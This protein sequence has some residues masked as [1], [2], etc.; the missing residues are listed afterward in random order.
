MKTRDSAGAY[1]TQPDQ[2]TFVLPVGSRAGLKFDSS[3]PHSFGFELLLIQVL[4]GRRSALAWTVLVI[5]GRTERLRM[6][7]SAVTRLRGGADAL[8]Y[9]L[10]KA[11]VREIWSAIIRVESCW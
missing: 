1:A 2:Q 8:Q 9:K 7:W 3:R 4:G 11:L 10:V 6:L 5:V